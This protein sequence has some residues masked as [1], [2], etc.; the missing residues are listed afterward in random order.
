MEKFLETESNDQKMKKSKMAIVV[1]M[2]LMQNASYVH[3]SN[4]EDCYSSFNYTLSQ[5][6]QTADQQANQ[7]S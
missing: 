3:S 5:F 2:V 7:V 4:S 1:L 6:L